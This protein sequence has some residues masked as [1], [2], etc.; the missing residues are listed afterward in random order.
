[1]LAMYKGKPS[2]QSMRMCFDKTW[3]GGNKW[4][5]GGD[6]SCSLCTGNMESQ[7]HILR[8]CQHHEM[9]SLRA[10]WDAR[11]AEEIVTISKDHRELSPVIKRLFHVATSHQ[12][13]FS[14]YTG[15]HTPTVAAELEG[16]GL[17]ATPISDKD[18]RVVLRFLKL[19]ANAGLALY[20]CRDK[21]IR[22]ELRTAATAATRLSVRVA[23]G[24]KRTKTKTTLNKITNYFNILQTD[25]E[26]TDEV[27]SVK[28]SVGSGKAKPRERKSTTKRAAVSEDIRTFSRD[29]DRMVAELERRCSA[30]ASVGTR[31]G[32]G[33]VHRML[34]LAKSVVEAAPGGSSERTALLAAVLG[35]ARADGGSAGRLQ[36]A[37]RRAMSRTDE[38][39]RSSASDVRWRG[40]LLLRSLAWLGEAV[41]RQRFGVSS[42]WVAS[43]ILDG[44]GHG[45]ALSRPGRYCSQ[46]ASTRVARRPPRVGIGT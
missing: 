33:R 9:R 21:I 28:V 6:S 40:G 36:Q 38:W 14:I 31:L 3:H 17:W 18:Y 43:E 16:S 44:L 12:E 35:V 15:L 8:E 37:T 25:D 42:G 27:M 41:Q 26:V 45:N 23:R 34:E 24:L 1:M 39:C 32:S 20:S 46:C 5:G 4:K 7:Q 11:I 22:G 30:E 29:V 10:E 19:F 2:G 13:G